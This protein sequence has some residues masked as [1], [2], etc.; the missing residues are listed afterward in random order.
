MQT[1]VMFS[2]RGISMTKKEEKREAFKRLATKRTNAVLN[3]IRILGN[4]SNPQLYEYT[5][6]EIIKIFDAIDSELKVARVQF[7]NSNKSTFKL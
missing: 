7:V 3:H 5:E 4:C 1:E 6:A 2:R